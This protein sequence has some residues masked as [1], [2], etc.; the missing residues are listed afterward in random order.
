M[1]LCQL[2]VTYLLLNGRVATASPSS[3]LMRAGEQV[4]PEGGWLDQGAQPRLVIE[5]RNSSGI[6]TPSLFMHRVNS[7]DN[8][9]A[10]ASE[11]DNCT[12]RLTWGGTAAS[13]EELAKIR[14][15]RH[16]ITLLPESPN[17]SSWVHHCED[18]EVL[19]FLRKNEGRVE[20]AVKQLAAHAVWRLSPFGAE[21]V[22]D[23]EEYSRSNVHKEIFWLGTTVDGCPALVIRTQAH[24][25]ADYQEDPKV[26][27]YS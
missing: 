20:D 24:D 10:S 12:S 17:M 18:T 8:S 21:T 2:F 15:I 25:G 19:R 6:I 9:S 1:I 14:T 3:A 22:V 11:D 7:S 4:I 27:L 5:E 23:S 16:K 13:N 26:C